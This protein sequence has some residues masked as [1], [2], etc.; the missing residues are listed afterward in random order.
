MPQPDTQR[1]EVGA[2]SLGAIHRIVTRQLGSALPRPWLVRVHGASGGNPLYAVELAR[3]E[4]RDDRRPDR[5]RPPTLVELAQQ[6]MQALPEETRDALLLVAAEPQPKVALLS[7]AL[8]TDA[9][10][11]LVPAFDV[12]LVE[13]D[14]RQVRFAHPVLASAIHTGAPE[15]VRRDAHAR[16]AGAATSVEQRGHHLALATVEPDPEVAAAVE[17]AARSARARGARAEAAELFRRAGE[18]TPDDD[19]PSRGRRLVIAADCYF[20]AG[21]AQQARALLEEAV[22]L[23]GPSRPEALWR[24]GRVLDET[25]GFVRSREQWEEALAT[26]NLALVVNVR[27]SMA[28]A[29]LFIDGD[30]ALQDAAAGVDAAERLNDRRLLALA[31]AMEA[32]VRGVLGDSTYRVPLDRGLALE[33]D[34]VLEE[35]HSPSAV[36]ADLGRLSLDLETS[37]QG[38]EAVLR[39][40]EEVGDARMET[41]CAYGLGMVETLAGNWERASELAHRATELS[42]QVTLLGLPAVRLTALVAA[43]TGDVERCRELLG[44]CDTTARQ[45]GD[46][47]NLL[48]T[49]A[50]AGFLELS[51]GASSAAAEALAEASAIQAE[52]GIREPGVTRFL[53]DLSEALAAEGRTDEAERAV[54]VFSAQADELQ[55]EWAHPLIARAE[56]EVLLARGEVDAALVRLEA[57]VAD[58]RLLPMPLER[59]R[60][61]V[62][63]GSAQRRARQRRSAR[64]T[65]QRAVAV[66]VD[67]GAELWTARAQAELGRIGGRTTSSDGLTPTEERVADLVAEG[68]SNKQVASELVVS[69][70]TV[71]AALTSIYRKLDVH[72]RTEMAHKLAESARVK[73]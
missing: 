69:V 9:L 57:A 29:A 55:R 42:E 58:E 14:G 32:Y 4:L 51:L 39:R 73:Q 2:L 70:H 6:R 12:G 45:M 21:G 10:E 17:R 54:A 20:D 37:R 28:L 36:A 48:G 68:M 18:L 31:L 27:R 41:W 59:A 13:L 1:L 72:S 23:D 19:G 11:T 3:T 38:Y 24:L 43:S 46:K 15:H 35:L 61:L 44:A 8:G 62:A 22:T 67:L 64:E 63:L 16:L 56:G 33:D 7:A 5:D 34:T 52:L 71:E 25:E 50:I 53:I 60:T 49:L 65:L 47:M 66:F 40:A 26:D 30:I